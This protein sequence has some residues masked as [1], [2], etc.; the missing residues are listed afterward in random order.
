MKPE[1]MMVPELLMVPVFCNLIPEETIKLSPALMVKPF[2]EQTDGAGV[3]GSN[4]VP[5]MSSQEA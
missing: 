2:T 4:Q 5:P 1:L 3:G